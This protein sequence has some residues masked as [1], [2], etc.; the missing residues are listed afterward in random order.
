MFPITWKQY[1]QEIIEKD[2]SFRKIMQVQISLLLCVDPC[3]LNARL[4]KSC[5]N[6]SLEPKIP[7]CKYLS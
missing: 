3:D 2:L 1:G 7:D 4:F 6:Q 5:R